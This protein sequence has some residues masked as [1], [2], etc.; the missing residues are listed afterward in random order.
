MPLHVGTTVV[1]TSTHADVALSL[2]TWMQTT[3]LILEHRRF[4]DREAY[5]RIPEEIQPELAGQ[6]IILVTNTYP[7]EQI[8]Q[9]ILLLQALEEVIRSHPSKSGTLTIAIP[10]Y[11]YARQDK[12]FLPGESI[13]ST[14]LATHF[15]LHCDRMAIL[16]VH[17]KEP[18]DELD[19]EVL[20]PT[21]I[22]EI[23]EFFNSGI[24]IDIV[25]AP[26]AGS[27]ERA[28]AAAKLMQVPF[29]HLTKRRIDAHTVVHEPKEL[30]VEGA[31]VLIID[32]MIS[33]GGTIIRA[34]QSL[35]EQGAVE[36]HAACT[37]GL[38]TAGATE[39]LLTSLDSVVASTSLPNPV[40]RID[41][42][43]SI[44]RCLSEAGPPR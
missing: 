34:T 18:F 30:D 22:P 43:K 11:G 12:Q 17:A 20:H 16:D 3:N 28:S 35:R 39:R 25:L 23:S 6:N 4:P 37:H 9:S 26:D 5:I 38:F 27:V 40:A 44:A 14:T 15:S 42:G 13:S 32:D 24:E 31:R 8:V 1:S 7:D 10:Y 33:T 29:T 36:V 19:I 2:A 41:A 21:L